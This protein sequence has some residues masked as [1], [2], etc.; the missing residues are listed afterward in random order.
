[1]T[2]QIKLT[3]GK[4]ALVDAEDFDRINQWKWYFC[5]GYANRSKDNVS[6][7]RFINETPKGLY[8]D[9]INR[10]KLDNRK[11]NLRTVTKSQN[12]HNTGPMKNNKSG[13]KGIYWYQEKGKWKVQ[14]AINKKNIHLGYFTDLQ[15]AIKARRKLEETVYA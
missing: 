1:M 13:Y 9:H 5:H 4:Y 15:Q 14:I 12:D 2:K 3:Q 7:H 10:D 6:M 8:T 11:V